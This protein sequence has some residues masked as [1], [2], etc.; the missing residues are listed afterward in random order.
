MIDI[1]SHILPGVDDGVQTLE[2]A[3][4]ML[5]IAV[6]SGVKTQVL[7]PHIQPGRFDNTKDYLLRRFQDFLEAVRAARIDIELRL[8]AEVHVCPQIMGMVASDT[9]PWLGTYQ[10]MKTFLL[11][12]PQSKPPA[13]SVNLV[14]WLVN[15]K[16]LPIIVH[17]ERCREW[18]E[19]P[20]RLEQLVE[21]GCPLQITASS[22]LGGFGR[23]AR[24]AALRFLTES[25]APIAVASDCHNLAYRPPDI[26]QGYAWLNDKFGGASSTRLTGETPAQ[27]LGLY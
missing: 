7:T 13:G 10:G 26:D 4:E 19:H 18:Q 25:Q 8:A 11:E 9:L 2:D 23:G 14:R 21:F 3:L 24:D 20:E 17:P 5:R 22:L 27:L 1:H 15:R 16:V 12:F 6:E